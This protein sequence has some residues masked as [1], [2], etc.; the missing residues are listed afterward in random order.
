MDRITYDETIDPATI[1]DRIAARVR[2]ADR[3]LAWR[4]GRPPRLRGHAAVRHLVHRRA[5]ARVGGARRARPAP[6]GRPTCPRT[7]ARSRRS[8]GCSPMPATTSTSTTA[9]AAS[10]RGR[11]SP[12]RSTSPIASWPPGRDRTRGSRIARPRTCSSRSGIM[13]LARYREAGL[14]SGSARTS[15]AVPTRR[16]SRS[17]GSGLR[18]GRAAHGRPARRGPSSG[19][20]TGCDSGTLDGARALGLDDVIGSLEAGKEADLIA[21]DPASTRRSA[22]GPA[23]DDPAE[24]ASRLIFR[25]IR[26][27]SAAP[28]SGD[29]VWRA[30]GH[31]VD[32]VDPEVIDWLASVLGSHRRRRGRATAGKHVV[33]PR[34]RGRPGPPLV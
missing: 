14:R 29:G 24:L 34:P 17:C 26:P 22:G 11:S 28:G 32:V 8:R 4:R 12:T 3:A 16:S 30:R 6:G 33:D 13:P 1:L 25:P 19:R 7:A 23:D 10:A 5:A 31:A 21:I 15:P 27:W 9:P 20:S 18:P 2:R